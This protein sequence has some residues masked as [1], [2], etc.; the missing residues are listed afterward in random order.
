MEKSVT[1]SKVINK[2][3]ICYKYKSNKEEYRSILNF[4][5]TL[6]SEN[7]EEFQDLLEKKFKEAGY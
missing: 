2:L 7:E 5:L 3:I 4:A 6:F 1:M